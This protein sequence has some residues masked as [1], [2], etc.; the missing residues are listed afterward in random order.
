MACISSG[1]PRCQ[2]GSE[3]IKYSEMW[4]SSTDF[5]QNIWDNEYVVVPDSEPCMKVAQGQTSGNADVARYYAEKL[6]A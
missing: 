5:C 4:E 3:C 2:E 6:V 1:L